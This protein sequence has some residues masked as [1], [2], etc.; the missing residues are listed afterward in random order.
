ML[1]SSN[2]VFKTIERDYA[3]DDVNRATYRGITVKTLLLLVIAAVTGFLAIIYMPIEVLYSMLIVASI[4]ALISVLI[5]TRSPRLAM[6]FGILYSISEGLI[7]GV[8]TAIFEAIVPGVAS[9]AILAT[10]V[11]FIVMLFLYSSRTIRVT[12]RFSK[13]MYAGLISILLFFVISG[14]LSI[15]GGGFA[16]NILANPLISI[17]IGVIMIIFGALMLTL[18]FDRAEML[19]EGGADKRYEWVAAIGLMVT[20]IW[21]YVEVL[22]VVALLAASRD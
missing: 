13:I 14:V 17:V 8:L 21:I 10:L 12:R 18:D 11:I 15:F 16:L 9:T 7:L 3:Y 2:P 5:A 20:I 22:R 1:R 6:P 19:V 4:V